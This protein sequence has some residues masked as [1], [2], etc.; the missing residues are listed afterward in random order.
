[1]KTEKRVSPKW[2]S[3]KRSPKKEGIKKRLR[4]SATQAK[5]DLLKEPHWPK[6]NR[7]QLAQKMVED[8]LNT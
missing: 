2:A 5:D 4:D 7:L 6:S 3:P 1:M 8:S